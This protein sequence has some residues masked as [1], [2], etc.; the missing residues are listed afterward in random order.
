[1]PID[2]VRL[3]NNDWDFLGEEL[4]KKLG[5]WDGKNLSIEGRTFYN[6]SLSIALLY[7]LSFY[8][9]PVEKERCFDKV[10][11]FFL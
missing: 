4:G 8:R 10:R 3:K 2:E 9:I 5:C 1:M 6:T 7:M 11:S